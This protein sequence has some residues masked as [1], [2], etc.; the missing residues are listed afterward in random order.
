MA[1]V[2]ITDNAPVFII[3]SGVQ[4]PP[5]PPAGSALMPIA[6]DVTAGTILRSDPSGLLQVADN[7]DT[8]GDIVGVALTAGTA[9][10]LVPVVSVG[11]VSVPGAE[12]G[13]TYY[14][15]SAGGFTDVPP[16]SGI[17]R[18]M[19]EC[20]EPGVIMLEPHPSV[21]RHIWL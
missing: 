10:A 15:G 12:P 2:I 13:K 19:G 4:G 3:E 17:F 9:G 7:T 1:D 11:S 16:T 14:L 8:L 5:G 6:I 20:F 21:R 18:I